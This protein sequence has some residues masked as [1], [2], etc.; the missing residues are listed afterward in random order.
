MHYGHRPGL[1]D[2]Q[3]PARW[4]ARRGEADPIV[5]RSPH[6]RRLTSLFDRKILALDI[7]HRPQLPDEFLSRAHSRTTPAI[8][9]LE[10]LLRI[11]WM[12]GV[13]FLAGYRYYNEK[14]PK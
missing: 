4:S 11:Q 9:D 3:E 5:L 7:Q 1:P 6:K 10:V 8:H 13:G 14:D 2:W 12:N